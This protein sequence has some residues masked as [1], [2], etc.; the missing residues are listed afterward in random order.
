[1]CV[2]AHAE[3]HWL[4]S[5]TV[6]TNTRSSHILAHGSLPVEL[7]N[8]HDLLICLLLIRKRCVPFLL[9]KEA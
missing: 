5:M 7:Q 8:V 4:D 3:E 1:M 6:V 2:T 9:Q